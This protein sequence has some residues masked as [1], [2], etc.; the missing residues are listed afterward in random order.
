MLLSGVYSL[1]VKILAEDGSTLGGKGNGVYFS[2]STPPAIRRTHEYGYVM[3]DVDWLDK[4]PP[5]AA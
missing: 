5:A 4:S 2:V 3:T 1:S